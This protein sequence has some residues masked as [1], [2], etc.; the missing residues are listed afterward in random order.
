MTGFVRAAVSLY[1]AC[2]GSFTGADTN[3]QPLCSSLR[4]SANGATRTKE[5]RMRDPLYDTSSDCRKGGFRDS[6]HT[7]SI[8]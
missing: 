6:E 3:W 8:Y 1:T 5:L 7:F 4:C 2:A